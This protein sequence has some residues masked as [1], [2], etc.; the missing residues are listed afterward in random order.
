MAFSQ[1]NKKKDPYINDDSLAVYSTHYSRPFKY[2]FPF[3]KAEC[4]QRFA[5]AVIGFGIRSGDVIAEVGAASGWLE[6]VFSVLV[7]S[8]T[9]YVQDIDTHFL[10]KDQ[11]DKM[12]NW[13]T[14]VRERPQTNQFRYVI[15]TA[16]ETNLPQDFFDKI[17]LNNSF[18]EIRDKWSI[19]ED[20][21][22]K[23]KPDGQLIIHEDYSNIYKTIRHRGC[24][25]RAFRFDEMLF[26]LEEKGYVLAGM[27]EPEHSFSNYLVFKKYNGS[28]ESFLQRKRAADVHIRE[29]EKVYDKKT[30]RDSTH[31]IRL[32]QY[33][34]EHLPE[35]RTAYHTIEHF[36]DDAAYFWLWKKQ[37]AAAIHI[38][39]MNLLLYPESANVYDSLGEAYMLNKQ[40]ET[41]LAYYARS[42]ELDPA[43][44]NAEE[45]IEK[46]R[47]LMKKR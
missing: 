18:H 46:I 42:L 19:L 27:H 32:A 31:T 20:I 23:L 11:F 36:I 9:F 2:G 3:K 30:V 43:N 39:R 38:F 47:G 10:N 29:L 14:S 26:I 40:Y 45:Q 15:G 5:E 16:T 21:Y 13:Y 17:I 1:K 37:Y 34:E 41:A 28:S 33:L 6:G 35:I 7:D 12:L 44:T 8:V 4:E 25:I 24:G 22:T